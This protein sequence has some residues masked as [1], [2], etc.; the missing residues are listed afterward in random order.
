MTRSIP[1]IEARKGLTNLPEV[2][3]KDPQLG[4][5]AVTRR[6]KA[7]LAVLPWEF[8]ESLVETLEVLSDEKLMTAL[9]KSLKELK[10]GKLIPWE[11]VKADLAL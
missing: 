1:M 9:K 4:A 6:G 10:A 8:Y 7:V 2:F 11:K 3:Q 5:V